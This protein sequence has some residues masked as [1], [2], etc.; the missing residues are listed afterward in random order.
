MKA[1][2][3]L[4]CLS[5]YLLKALPQVSVMIGDSLP[6]GLRGKSSLSAKSAK[7]VWMIPRFFN[8]TFHWNVP[9]YFFQRIVHEVN[10]G[11]GASGALLKMKTEEHSDSLWLAKCIWLPFFPVA[12]RL[13]FY[14]TVW[15][16]KAFNHP[17]I[18]MPDTVRIGLWGFLRGSGRT[19]F[20]QGSILSKQLAAA[21]PVRPLRC[22]HFPLRWWI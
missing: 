8:R 15:T 22:A 12:R 7:C 19:C 13:G 18:Q 4:S 16:S 21:R 10:E 3:Q 9:I 1:K 11:Q 14:T 17:E 5:K 20:Q 2:C 6:S